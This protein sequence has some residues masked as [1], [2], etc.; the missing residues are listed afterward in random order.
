MKDSQVNIAPI[1]CKLSNLRV[2]KNAPDVESPNLIL[3]QD[4]LF[5]VQVTVEFGS[6]GAIALMPLCL[7]IEVNFF[8]EP[9]G[10]GSKVELGNAL[11]N[12][13]GDVFTYT[14]TVTKVSPA[15]IGLC[16]PGIYQVTAVL[17]VGA[18]NWPSLIIG[19]IEGLTIQI[20]QPC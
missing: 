10:L 14:P 9:Y 8:A 3:R 13:V 20:Y 1:T 18:A 7:L 11:V 2:C 4:E 6:S 16:C 19:L 5:Q 15:E 17:R 12:T